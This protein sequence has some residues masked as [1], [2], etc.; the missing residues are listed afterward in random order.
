MSKHVEFSLKKAVSR[1][2]LHKSM[3]ALIDSD[4]A[5]KIYVAIILPILINFQPMEQ[6][7]KRFIQ[8]KSLPKDERKGSSDTQLNYHHQKAS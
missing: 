5:R 8:K 6:S 2:N 4:V 3:R 1:I 7:Q